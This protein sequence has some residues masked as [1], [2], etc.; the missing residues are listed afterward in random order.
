MENTNGALKQSATL[1]RQAKSDFSQQISSL[2]GKLANIGAS[3]VG[4][5]S[6][7]FIKVKQ[8]WNDQ[9]QRLLGALEEF[10]QNLEGV[11]KTF[12]VTDADVT[13]GMNQ[14]TNRLG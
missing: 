6:V 3:W 13:A 10:S 9:V 1:T 2:D 11:D 4:E 5:G 8:A 7:A 12:N 14:L